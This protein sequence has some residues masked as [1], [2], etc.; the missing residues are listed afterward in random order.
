MKEVKKEPKKK[1]KEFKLCCPYSYWSMVTFPMASP[2]KKRESFHT[3]IPTRSH[4][5]WKL[6]SLLITMFKNSLFDG[7]RSRFLLLG[8]GGC[9]SLSLNCESAVTNTTAEEA[10]LSL[11]V[12]KN[13]DHRLPH[14][15]W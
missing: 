8:D 14:G 2:L 3:S 4:Q 5:S 11:I 10:F 7:F 9:L 15:I 12:S 1:K 6:T 13:R